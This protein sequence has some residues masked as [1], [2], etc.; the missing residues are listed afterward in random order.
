VLFAVFEEGGDYADH[1]SFRGWLSLIRRGVPIFG[2]G[3]FGR[4]F[5]YDRI[6][7]RFRMG[8]RY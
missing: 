8:N 1:R 3:L 5:I 7:Q 4:R 2:V 6:I